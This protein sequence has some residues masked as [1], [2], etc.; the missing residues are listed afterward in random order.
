MATAIGVEVKTVLHRK[1][2]NWLPDLDE[3]ESKISSKTRLITICHPNNPTGA[4]LDREEMQRLVDIAAKHDVY[5]HADEVYKDAELVGE[6]PASFAD[7]YDKSIVTSGLSKA[8][9]LPGLR[10]GWLVGQAQDIY[11]A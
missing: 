9:A 1:D 3:L 8:M 5:L 10:V 7:L 2:N 6:E 4:V 11:A